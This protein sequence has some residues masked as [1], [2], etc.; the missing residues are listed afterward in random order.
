MDLDGTNDVLMQE[1][2]V[3]ATT[4]TQI[5]SLQ[6]GA[7]SIILQNNGV[8]GLVHGSTAQ[9]GRKPSEQP[10]RDLKRENEVFDQ[11]LTKRKD[12]PRPAKYEGLPYATLQTG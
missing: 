5:S 10:I 3:I 12:A 1:E 2:G 7:P 4:E 8:P 11:H 9:T 6:H